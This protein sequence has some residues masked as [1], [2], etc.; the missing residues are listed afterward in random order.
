MKNQLYILFLLF[1]CLSANAQQ[2]DKPIWRHG[3][4][5]NTQQK[6]KLKPVWQHSLSA[7]VQTYTFHPYL[8]GLRYNARLRTPHE[9]T[10]WSFGAS[11]AYGRNAYEWSFFDKHQYGYY[12][13]SSQLVSFLNL[14]AYCLFGKKNLVL[15]TGLD[16]GFHARQ[17]EKISEVTT[18]TTNTPAVTN[19]NSFNSKADILTLIAP[20]GLRYQSP[21]NGITVWA[22]GGVGFYV[23]MYNSN[24]FSGKPFFYS[25]YKLQA[26][27]GY[28]FGQ[29]K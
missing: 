14:H 9:W 22:D 5:A 17:L 24:N 28:S 7:N 19:I 8:L 1:F 26:G 23:E 29:R 11:S 16:I 25:P 27:I 4:L 20:L 21:R 12:K 3:L 13:Y 18:R 6:P 10:D 2:K 15:Q